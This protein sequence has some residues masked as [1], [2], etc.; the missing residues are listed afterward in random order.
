M[1]VKT[2]GLRYSIDLCGTTNVPLQKMNIF[3]GI[4][5]DQKNAIKD[6]YTFM[7]N[8][9][10]QIKDEI[11]FTPLEL[12]S[13][14][15][16]IK[17]SK[18]MKQLKDFQELIQKGIQDRIFKMEDQRSHIQQIEIHGLGE[19]GPSSSSESTVP[20]D[21]GIDLV[22][23][24]SDR[25]WDG[26]VDRLSGILHG[27]PLLRDDEQKIK[28]EENELYLGLQ[29]LLFQQIGY[30]YKQN[31]ISGEAFKKFFQSKITLEMAVLNM[32]HTLKSPIPLMN[33]LSPVTILNEWTSENYRK[34]YEGEYKAII[35]I[36]TEFSLNVPEI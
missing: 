15:D 23:E 1:L 8:Q 28:K 33:L 4:L 3:S 6:D 31:M 30:M 34:M 14:P 7:K 32:I 12:R 11:L 29:N 35:L 22:E 10:Q 27:I 25:V 5:L 18:T 16:F 9:L 21:L 17:A 2:A 19:N 24:I 26:Q 13:S 36:T 20:K